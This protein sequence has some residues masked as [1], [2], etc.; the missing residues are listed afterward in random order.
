MTLLWLFVILGIS[1]PRVFWGRGTRIAIWIP[2]NRY[3]LDP[4]ASVIRWSMLAL[5]V[6]L[7]GLGWQLPLA[8]AVWDIVIVM[9]GSVIVLLF[10]YFPDLAYYCQRRLR[11]PDREPR[12]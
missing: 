3:A 11:M 2:G 7:I 12:S 4:Q 5:G 9:A 8:R 6:V 1:L 10:V